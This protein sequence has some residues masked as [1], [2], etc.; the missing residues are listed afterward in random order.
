[1]IR[2][3]AV[4]VRFEE[5]TICA[6]EDTNFLKKAPECKRIISSINDDFV[7]HN[8]HI[9]HL[10]F[11]IE[12]PPIAPI[13]SHRDAPIA[14]EM[15]YV[16][17]LEQNPYVA[18]DPEV[19]HIRGFQDDRTIARFQAS[20][21]KGYTN[22]QYTGVQDEESGRPVLSSI[23]DESGG[24]R[25]FRE[26]EEQA[27]R[28]A[29]EVKF[30]TRQQQPSSSITE[31]EAGQLSD[32]ELAKL[33]ENDFTQTIKPRPAIEIDEADRA[34][35]FSLDDDGGGVFGRQAPVD[36]GAPKMSSKKAGK[37][38]MGQ[39][40]V[41]KLAPP[42]KQPINTELTTLTQQTVA[43]EVGASQNLMPPTIED[44]AVSFDKMYER[45][46]E[47]YLDSRT[48]PDL[49][50]IPKV[51]KSAGELEVKK[52]TMN[53]IVEALAAEGQPIVIGIDDVEITPERALQKIDELFNKATKNTII[54][55]NQASAPNQDILDAMN[56]LMNDPFDLL[57]D[58]F[59]GLEEFVSPDQSADRDV[60]LKAKLAKNKAPASSSSQ[61]IQDVEMTTLDNRH[62]SILELNRLTNDAMANK[63]NNSGKK[64]I[65]DIALDAVSV[66]LTDLN[67]GK[68]SIDPMAPIVEIKTRTQ[69]PNAILK[70]IPTI[71]FPPE[72]GI[73]K[74]VYPP[75]EHF[76][77]SSK[78]YQFELAQYNK[79][80]A[81]IKAKIKSSN[82]HGQDK[83]LLEKQLNLII[84][85]TEIQNQK[86]FN[87]KVNF[88]NITDEARVSQLKLE[89]TAYK[90]ILE[91]P[92]AQRPALSMSGELGHDG[93]PMID[94]AEMFRSS[95]IKTVAELTAHIGKQTG[96]TTIN[97]NDLDI[98]LSS[99]VKEFRSVVTEFPQIQDINTSGIFK[100]TT[101]VQLTKMEYVGRMININ[102]IELA[103]GSV[104]AGTGVI[105]GMVVG[106]Y[107]QKTGL[108][109]G[110][111]GATM[112]GAMAGGAGA[113]VG[114]LTAEALIAKTATRFGAM[115]VSVQEGETALMT[116]ARAEALSNRALFMSAV[117]GMVIG[118]ALVPLDQALRGFL[119]KNGYTR[120]EAGAITG[121]TVATVGA[122]AATMI[123]VG[124]AI[125]EGVA[126][127]PETFGMSLLMAAGSI[128]V[129]TGMGA[130]FGLEEDH[131]ARDDR[132]SILATR[133]LIIKH[134]AENN[135][136]V[137]ATVTA[138]QRMYNIPDSRSTAI[139][140]NSLESNLNT[141]FH[142]EDWFSSWFDPNTYNPMADDK[143]IGMGKPTWNSETYTYDDP[144]GYNDFIEMLKTVYSGR[145]YTHPAMEGAEPPSDDDKKTGLLMERMIQMEVKYRAQAYGAEGRSIVDSIPDQGISQVERDYLSR[146]T[147]NTWVQDVQLQGDLRF[148]LTVASQV[149]INNA[150][151]VM[152]QQ[153][154]QYQNGDVSQEILDWANQDTNWDKFYQD[155]I[156]MDAQNRIIEN[157]Q[158]TGAGLD[159][160]T[161]SII[162]AAT[163]DPHFREVFT[164]Y[165]TEMNATAERYH[166]SR[167]QLLQ[168]QQMPD[169]NSRTIAFQR[170]QFETLKL[171]TQTVD[172]S[173]DMAAFLT[174][175]QSDGFYDKDQFMF[176]EDPTSM[177][178]WN[179]MDSQ[180]YQAHELGMTLRQYIDYLH[181]LGLGEEGSVNNLPEY[182]AYEI[183]QQR[184][185][186]YEHFDSYLKRTGHD[187][188]Y[189]YDSETGRFRYNVGTYADIAEE[190]RPMF[191]QHLLY[192]PYLPEGFVSTTEN[193]ANMIHGM[194]EHNQRQT[195][196]YNIK[197]YSE[198]T[199][200]GGEYERMTAAYNAQAF[201]TGGSYAVFDVKGEY[202]ARAAPPYVP[203]STNINDYQFSGG[204]P[205][206]SLGR[207]PKLRRDQDI[208]AVLLPEYRDKADEIVRNTEEDY[209]GR[210]LTNDERQWIYKNIFNEQYYSSQQ[211]QIY[212]AQREQETT[213]REEKYAI[214]TAGIGLNSTDLQRAT[215]VNMTLEDY[216]TWIN[217]YKNDFIVTAK[218]PT[219]AEEDDDDDDGEPYT[220][221][222][223]EDGKPLTRAE[224]MRIND[225]MMRRGGYTSVERFYED[226]PD[227]RPP[228]DMV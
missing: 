93:L 173:R 166:I 17:Y 178:G 154:E 15:R 129:S 108:F 185:Q 133:K 128:A 68:I 16:Y 172:E 136:D 2:D 164:T 26:G 227:A 193:Y 188:E 43:P 115:A 131:D 162:R 199:E 18:Q 40:E 59:G 19:Y 38:R 6:I 122:T 200:F 219:E 207:P 71:N 69:L 117:E 141:F 78:T 47:G 181:Q 37:Q 5:T 97:I 92:I 75:I 148:N 226:H 30:K 197:L 194:N 161:P 76:K 138:V 176:A 83:F 174:S 100:V 209:G 202:E 41:P 132:N 192:D 223:G 62:S 211:E 106:E 140:D 101:K 34:G 33:I 66:E 137:D 203:K 159:A 212:W 88:P 81:A 123:Q 182:N 48:N 168:L 116:A 134:L 80:M 13:I 8:I 56:T 225:D 7:P 130:Y 99:V 67:I 61:P 53:Q 224:M 31:Y 228:D 158:S 84:E 77:S 169:Y 125:V 85:Y 63:A 155:N 215:N 49:P 73:V 217:T 121:A 210:Q 3:R 52:Y 205:V 74:M 24:T 204:E 114:S 72:L 55:E 216:Y 156:Q 198:I 103:I 22:K 180:I 89:I 113:I 23:D 213:E 21:K 152:L 39:K 79:A 191:Q 206:T 139:I 46:M 45:F 153:W 183:H 214:A 179:P 142:P 87:E 186:D 65:I 177:D 1:M 10:S 35:A 195:D 150:H 220:G 189:D 187:L 20:R 70:T 107:L 221:Y 44:Y 94:R 11:Q 184:I 120:Q 105:A 36:D 104:S 60:R 135:Y 110:I 32:L 144:N 218:N 42:S 171:N 111:I 119:L 27:L 64:V 127:A 190:Q 170:F 160:N 167:A 112:V 57:A 25:M 145:V 9:P 51:I 12:N 54:N 163:R 143:P 4:R 208:Y 165:E 109:T 82:L 28:T 201:R 50:D 29:D 124:T 175:L 151:L 102:P 91:T 118:A 157:F 90:M 147:N 146:K 126:L 196:E 96:Q 58:P 86:Y 98:A 14:P 95:G 222:L 149:K